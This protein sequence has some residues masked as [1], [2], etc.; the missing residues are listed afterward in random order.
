MAF[1]LATRVST[2]GP[3]KNLGKFVASRLVP[4]MLGNALPVSLFP[5]GH[6]FFGHYGRS[7]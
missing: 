3:R 6:N 4:S 1:G 7:R 2:D 5:G